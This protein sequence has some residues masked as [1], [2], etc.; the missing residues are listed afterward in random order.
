MANQTTSLAGSPSQSKT[1]EESAPVNVLSKAASQSSIRSTGDGSP[2]IPMNLRPDL[3][4][5][6]PACSGASDYV[7]A[8]EETT[9]VASPMEKPE[10]CFNRPQLQ[11]SLSSQANRPRGGT[12]SAS[13]S[14]GVQVVLD[15]TG[16]WSELANQSVTI[17]VD[18]LEGIANAK[19][20]PTGMLAFLGRKKGREKSPKPSERGVLGKEGARVV[21]S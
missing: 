11:S 18:G 20:K 16:S 2:P 5:K 10:P 7:S 1:S 12:R 19:A 21:I 17:P 14:G 15:E 8:A 9:P 3:P 13:K 6:S 4:Q